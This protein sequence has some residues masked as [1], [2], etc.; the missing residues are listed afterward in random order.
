[1]SLQGP[2]NLTAWWKSIF[3]NQKQAWLTMHSASMYPLMPTGAHILVTVLE[4]TPLRVGDI[5]LYVDC[6]QL[7]AHRIFKINLTQNQCL[8]GGDNGLATSMIALDNIIG[9]VEKIKVNGKEIDLKSRRGRLLTRLMRNAGLGI[10]AL[11]QRWPRGGHLLH[12][13]FLH[14]IRIVFV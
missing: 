8:Q 4:Q 11:R 12:R 6:N 2:N 1:M 10:L 7:L 13:V 3:Q 5:V 9:I 14:F